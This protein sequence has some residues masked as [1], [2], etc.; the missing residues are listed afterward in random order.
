MQD[1]CALLPLHK[2]AQQSHQVATEVM[3]AMEQAM[4]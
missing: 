1:D 3:A 2:W 4:E